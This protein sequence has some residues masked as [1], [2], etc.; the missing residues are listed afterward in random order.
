MLLSRKSVGIILVV[1]CLVIVLNPKFPFSRA[2]RGVIVQGFKPVLVITHKSVN[3]VKNIRREMHLNSTLKHE[4]AQLTNELRLSERKIAQLK[5]YEIEN[6][7]LR[8]LLNLKEDVQYETLP[9][10]VIGRD[11][12]GASQLIIIDKGT[13]NGIKEDMP[14]VSGQGGCRQ[15]Y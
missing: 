1:L 3:F 14:V 2:I 13:K 6:K 10:R 12:T 15:S 11:L 8:T 7:R 9:A 5:E 4:N